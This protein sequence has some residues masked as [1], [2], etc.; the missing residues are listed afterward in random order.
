VAGELD[1][2]AA[3]AAVRKDF[4]DSAYW[5]GAVVTDKDGVAEI[6]VPMPENLTTWKIHAWSLGHGTVVGQGSAEVITAKDLLIRLQAP[7]FFVETDEVTLSANVHNY[8]EGERNIQVRL[9]LD[10]GVL[11]LADGQQPRHSLTI[12]AGED[13]RVD[14]RVRVVG[15]GEAVIRVSAVTGKSSDAMEMKYPAYVH[16]MLKTDSFSAAVRPDGESTKVTVTVPKKRRPEQTHL[17]VRYSPSIALAMVDALPY[18]AG[19]EYKHSEAALSRFVPL[20]ITRRIL[21]DMGVDLEAVKEKLTNL[22]P[23]EIGDA[24]KRAAQWKKGR[25]KA[26][27]D[28]ERVDGLIR[29]GLRDLTFLQNDDGGWGWAPGSKSDAHSTAY[30]VHGLQTAKAHGMALVPDLLENGVKWLEDYQKAEV[31]KIA[32]WETRKKQPW[33]PH[34][35]NLDAFVAMVLADAEKPNQQILDYLYRDRTEL[36]VYALAM[37][38]LTFDTLE[39]AERRDM[40]LRNV[41]QY[42]VVDKENQTA[43]LNLP[44]RR[45]WWCWYGSDI[46]A[47]AYFLKLLARVE[48]Q[49]AVASGVAK[50]LLNNRKH[51]T[52]WSCTRD[53]ALGIEALADFI[54]ASGESKPDMTVELLVDGTQHKEIRITADNLFTFDNVLHLRG[55]ALSAGKHAIELRRT[56]KGPVYLNAYL[57]NFTLEDFITKAGL[58]IKVE[59][60]YYKLVRKDRDIKATGSR[61]QA[62]DYR[63]EHYDRMPLKSGARLAS[64]DLV[65]VE[66][67]LTSK[68]DYEHLLFEDYKPAGLEPVDLQSGWV[69]NAY[70]ELRDEKVAFLVRRLPRGTQTITYRLRAE[71][72]GRFS[73]LPTKGLGV[74]AP[75]LRANSD[76]IK[77]NVVDR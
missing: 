72:P 48:P 26:V 38:G 23:Q 67:I 71:I 55:D 40:C 53:T 3:P 33:K 77:L 64:G 65:E 18:L 39:N 62:L 20:A 66:L 50:Y 59:R 1:T 15:I 41:K 35:D 61:G 54:T 7:R 36:S 4:A 31:E 27:F 9:N 51:A 42:L 6:E 28:N 49:S 74:Y 22:N 76:E 30:V 21:V 47:H 60:R 29:R 25:T 52:W 5:T 44:N 45:Y 24:G 14:W 37:L 12:P 68:N 11:A 73:A 63:V 46:E 19:Y 70:M 17:E 57:T 13:R 32:N 56:G 10:G 58:E 8:L 75:E 69:R 34:A 43:Y 2:D 16:G